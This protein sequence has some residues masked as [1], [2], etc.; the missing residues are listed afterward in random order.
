MCELKLEGEVRSDEAVV[1]GKPRRRRQVAASVVSGA[2]DV[3]VQVLIHRSG[4]QVC[5][6]SAEKLLMLIM[7]GSTHRHE[8]IRFED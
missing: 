8:M 4:W 5:T 1:D 6:N 2:V 3:D 7:S